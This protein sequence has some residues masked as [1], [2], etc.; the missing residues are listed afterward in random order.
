MAAFISAT[1]GP[2]IDAGSLIDVLDTLVNDQS[3]ASRLIEVDEIVEGQTTQSTPASD[4]TNY[5]AV[6]DIQKLCIT[7]DNGAQAI[8]DFSDGFRDITDTTQYTTDDQDN[9]VPPDNTDPDPYVIIPAESG[10]LATGNALVQQGLLW[11]I[12]N[13]SSGGVLFIVGGY[14]QPIGSVSAPVYVLN[15]TGRV[16]LTLPDEFITLP[17]SAY[18]DNKGNVA[19]IPA[20]PTSGGSGTIYYTKTGLFGYSLNGLFPLT[21]TNG[22]TLAV[23]SGVGWF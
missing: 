19:L 6:A 20:T 9:Q 2:D 12:I 10:G 14:Q 4:G 8:F 23:V 17:A 11:K 1:T 18:V 7:I 13:F 3:S 22:D 5:M 15:E 21:F 16:V